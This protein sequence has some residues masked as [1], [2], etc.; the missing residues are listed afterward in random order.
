MTYPNPRQRNNAWISI[1]QTQRLINGCRQLIYQHLE[2][3]VMNLNLQQE[4][5]LI[6]ISYSQWARPLKRCPRSVLLERFLNYWDT[7]RSSN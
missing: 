5:G 7:S 4:V 3:T 2:N 1:V 6:A